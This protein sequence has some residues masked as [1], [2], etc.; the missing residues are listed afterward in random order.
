MNLFFD[1]LLVWARYP[2]KTS[3]AKKS[4]SADMALDYNSYQVGNHDMAYGDYSLAGRQIR[5]IHGPTPTSDH[6]L[7]AQLDA[8]RAIGGIHLQHNLE[9]PAFSKGDLVRTE[10]LMGIER[11][12]PETFRL[13]STPL[14]GPGWSLKGEAGEYFM[15]YDTVEGFFL[16]YGTYAFTNRKENPAMGFD[17]LEGEAHRRME[18]RGDNGFYIGPRVMRDE[19]FRLAFLYASRAFSHVKPDQEEHRKRL[20][21]ALQVGVQGFIA[22]GALIQTLKDAYPGMEENQL[23]DRVF[24]ASFGQACKLDIDRGVVLNVMTRVY[25]QM[26]AGKDLTEDDISE[27]IGTVV[28]RAELVSGRT[29]ISDRYQPLSDALR[30]IGVNQENVQSA[31]QEYIGKGFGVDPKMLDYQSSS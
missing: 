5:A 6:L 3:M 22:V 7:Q 13:M 24:K 15:E 8:E 26:A 20:T 14:D 10:Y 28:G 31:L 12:Y 19:Q 16:K 2:D 30:L 9:H 17:A 1:K 4:H 21:K 11:D 25:F 23:Q 29:I 27:I 18:G